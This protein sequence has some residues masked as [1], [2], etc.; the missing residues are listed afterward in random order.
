M[1][2]SNRLDQ[3]I[4]R[5]KKVTEDNRRLNGRV[6]ELEAEM[7]V[8]RQKLAEEAKKSEELNE[9]IKIVKL[10]QNI[11]SGTGE[12]AEVTELKRKINEYIKE[13]DNCIAMLND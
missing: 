10:A 13:I 6:G 1:Q 11:G 2:L 5:A 3:L 7:V 9:K 8:L 12:N 4:A